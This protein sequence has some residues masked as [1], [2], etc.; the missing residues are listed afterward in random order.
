MSGLAPHPEADGPPPVD[1]T[2]LSAR[3]AANEQRSKPKGLIVAGLLVLLVGVVY[4]AVGWSSLSSAATNRRNEAATTRNVAFQ[5]AALERALRDGVAGGGD[6]APFEQFAQEADLVA[7]SVGLTPAPQ[8][9]SQIS[10]DDQRT[11]L[12]LQTYR[13]EN[14]RSRDL[15]A[16]LAWVSEV[17]E[18]V[19]GIVEISRLEL[20][21]RP[22]DWELD[23]TFVKPEF[24]R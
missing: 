1:R 9:R 22:R 20:T 21:P 5:K 13:Y 24:P 18:R 16:L 23:V 15:G 11:D 14:I 7:Q 19:P 12:V 8:L 2:E 17:P 4:M 6:Y 3:A 10:T